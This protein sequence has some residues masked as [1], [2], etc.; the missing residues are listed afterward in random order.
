MPGTLKKKIGIFVSYP[1]S[2]I[3]ANFN[4]TC[5]LKTV[6]LQ[7]LGM[8]FYSSLAYKEKKGLWT[9]NRDILRGK[10]GKNSFI[11]EIWYPLFFV[12]ALNYCWVCGLGFFFLFLF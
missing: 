11:L 9:I 6:F 2:P 12:W 4:S 1:V 10:E 5:T 8:A 7:I 3:V